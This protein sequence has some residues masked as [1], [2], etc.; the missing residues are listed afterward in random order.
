MFRLAL[1]IFPS[2]PFI[3]SE[4]MM[5]S[6]E[7]FGKTVSKMS[8]IDKVCFRVQGFSINCAS[9]CFLILSK[10][11]IKTLLHL[12]SLSLILLKNTELIRVLFVLAMFYRG[13]FQIIQFAQ[14]EQL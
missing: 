1:K 3:Q 7:L 4:I 8:L 13:F 5:S 12:F 2:Q 6:L 14:F 9:A 10:P 11:S